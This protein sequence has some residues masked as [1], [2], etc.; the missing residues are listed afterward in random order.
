MPDRASSEYQP[1]A[2]RLTFET[3]V[4]YRPVG[5]ARWHA[6]RPVNISRS[7]LL[8]RSK[9]SLPPKAP[10]DVLFSL[11]PELGG[12]E[13][14]HVMC[15]GYVS[16]VERQSGG[17]PAAIATAFV[18]FNFL[19]HTLQGRRTRRVLQARKRTRDLFHNLNNELQVMLGTCEVALLNEAL[20]EQLRRQLTR[21]LQSGRRAADLVRQIN[22]AANVTRY[23]LS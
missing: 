13:R 20:P 10:V 21:I 14:L 22:E 15:C 18:D 8:F 9:H 7:G 4:R 1:R 23:K 6:G 11:P 12:Q 2:E 19:E 17:G 16:R 5:S 3:H